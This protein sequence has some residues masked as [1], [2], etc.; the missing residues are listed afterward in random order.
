MNQVPKDQDYRSSEKDQVSLKQLY[1]LSNDYVNNLLKLNNVIVSNNTTINKYQSYIIFWKAKL[2]EADDYRLLNKSYFQNLYYIYGYMRDN[3]FDFIR[4]FRV[5]RYKI[6]S[7]S[8]KLK[9]YVDLRKTLKIQIKYPV[10]NKLNEAMVLRRRKFINDYFAYNLFGKRGKPVYNIT[11]LTS[12]DIKIMTEVYDIIFFDGQIKEFVEKTNTTLLFSISN[13]N[14]TAGYCKRKGCVRTISLAWTVFG[15]IFE[16]D[17]KE[18]HQ[19]NGLKCK[20]RLECLQLTLEHELIHLLIGMSPFVPKMKDK[21]DKIYSSHGKLFKGLVFSYFG[22]TKVV[23]NLGHD[24][25][26]A[27]PKEKL[28]KELI[29][30]YKGSNGI[31]LGKIYDLN[32]V[33]AKIQTL[34][35][36]ILIIPYI[37]IVGISDEQEEDDKKFG[38]ILSKKDFKVGK[39]AKFKGQK[40]VVIEGIIE[41][42]NPKKAIIKK[43]NIVYTVP[44]SLMII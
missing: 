25:R 16:K 30:K 37:N 40:G 6:V 21:N 3:I 42:L 33:K 13:A 20:N 39:M 23:H 18:V 43:G 27:I 10:I 38:K 4:N 22:H 44:Y 32:P 36:I 12:D 34:Q 28:R 19:S 15:S 26:D 11:S 24:V 9:P 17:D 7:N 5:P 14:K 31:K 1:S 2:L 41:K 35:N 8:E 29:I